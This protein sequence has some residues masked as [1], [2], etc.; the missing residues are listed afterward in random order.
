LHP[1]DRSGATERDVRAWIEEVSG[2][3]PAQ[4]VER[5]RI[6]CGEAPEPDAAQS[7]FQASVK[8]PTERTIRRWSSTLESKYRDTGW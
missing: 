2:T 8:T 6:L 4:D 7:G 5:L 1:A 3:A